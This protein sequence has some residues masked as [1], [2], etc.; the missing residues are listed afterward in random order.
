MKFTA[1]VVTNNGIADRESRDSFFEAGYTETKMID[2]IM[3]I[4]DKIIS[5]YLF[6][7]AGFEIDFPLAEEL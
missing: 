7:L 2:V 4:V 6:K 1:S 5:N 3:V